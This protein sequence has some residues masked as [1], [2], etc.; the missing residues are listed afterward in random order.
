MI[1]LKRSSRWPWSLLAR[2]RAT[3]ASDEATRPAAPRVSPRMKQ[4]CLEML[5]RQGKLLP[6]KG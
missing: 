5:D 4:R 2:Q 1:G 6:R 3:A